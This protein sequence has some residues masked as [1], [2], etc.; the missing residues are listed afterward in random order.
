MKLEFTKEIN[1]LTGKP[2]YFLADKVYAFE[3]VEIQTNKTNKRGQNIGNGPV[4]KGT[5][6]YLSNVTKPVMIKK[7][8]K[9]W[10]NE[11]QKGSTIDYVLRKSRIMEDLEKDR[12]AAKNG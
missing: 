7:S 9:A 12:K 5:A 8:I 6:L 3:S 4:F 2:I 11:Q 1:L 10:I